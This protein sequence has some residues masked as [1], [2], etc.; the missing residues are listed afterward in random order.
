MRSAFY[1]LVNF[2]NTT[3]INDVYANAAR[4]IL[5]NIYLISECTITDVADFCFVSTATISRLCRKLNY[6]SFADFKMDVTMNLNYFNRDA[7]RLHFDHQLP[8][9][10]YL[11]KGKE[12]FK[13][14]FENIIDNLRATYDN[15]NYEDLE[16]I[17]D[18]IHSADKICFAG[19]FF[20]QSVSMQLQIE[21]SYLGKECSGMYPL[22]QQIL[23]IEQLTKNDVIIVSS[24]AGGFMIDH[25]DAMR[26][27]SK[28]PAYKIVITQ[29]DKFA[30]SNLVDMILQVGTDHQSLIGKFSITYIFEVLEALYHLK[31]GTKDKKKII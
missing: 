17:V 3:N 28:S 6:E 16:F 31:Y 21:L 12:V 7:L 8:Q 5:Q 20:T 13:A 24:I 19:N 11:H 10:E 4:M 15:I 29:L 26:A 27:I 14:H 18:K 1:N 25:P 22:Q 30:Y 23:V 2:I 9:R